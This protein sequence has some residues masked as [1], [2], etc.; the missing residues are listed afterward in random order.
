MILESFSASGQRLYKEGSFT[1]VCDDIHPPRSHHHTR[2]FV[3]HGQTGQSHRLIKRYAPTTT[4]RAAKTV[5]IASKRNVITGE[6]V[7]NCPAAA[8]VP[9]R[10]VRP[11]G[12]QI[13][14]RPSGVPAYGAPYRA[15]ALLDV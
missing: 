2:L 8:C 14:A 5:T 9:L 12:S 15:A 7:A 3:P 4:S 13:G 1:A 6:I 10:I 11:T